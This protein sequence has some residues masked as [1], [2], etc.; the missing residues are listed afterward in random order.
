MVRK[1]I[2][3]FVMI[4]F[5]S[6][7]HTPVNAA[8]RPHDIPNV[9]GDSG[10]ATLSDDLNGKSYIQ[11]SS[12][13]LKNRNTSCI[14]RP[15]VYKFEPYSEYIPVSGWGL[16]GWNISTDI[17]A[18]KDRCRYGHGSVNVVVSVNDSNVKLKGGYVTVKASYKTN[19]IGTTWVSMSQK[20]CYLCFGYYATPGL[21]RTISIT[22][23]RVTTVVW[24]KNSGSR[25]IPLAQRI[26][27]CD[28]IRRTCNSSR[29]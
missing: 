14:S 10:K 3:V 29:W 22:Y 6:S 21:S 5:T 15:N 24:G 9:R 8:P 27:T 17:S 23:V 2:I 26:M 16:T 11:L 19:G 20:H 4:M 7:M 28:I 18:I 25:W 12:N 13:E 1:L